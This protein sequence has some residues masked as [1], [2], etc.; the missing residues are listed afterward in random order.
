MQSTSS[1]T[2]TNQTKLL[3]QQLQEKE[4]QIQQ[5]QQELEQQKKLAQIG[6]EAA[7]ILHDVVSPISLAALC[8]SASESYCKELIEAYERAVD[9]VDQEF[10]DEY[11][12]E[13]FLTKLTKTQR[14]QVEIQKHAKRIVGFAD[15]IKL[16]LYPQQTQESE[17]KDV[18]ISEL[19]INTWQ[20]CR[21]KW[22]RSF[23]IKLNTD[24]EF[25]EGFRFNRQD[26]ERIILNLFD[27]A[28]Y[29]V[30]AKNKSLIYEPIVK[31]STKNLG[32]QLHLE[33]EDNGVG[34]PNEIK[35]KLFNPFVTTKPSYEGTGLGLA[36]VKELV[37]K[38]KGN[39][40]VQSETGHYTKFIVFFP[41]K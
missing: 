26:L 5:L 38:H 4:K 8:A 22:K 32:G 12:G 19:I 7:K 24:F 2:T 23:D 18:N 10:L 37:N 11:L 1:N 14:S 40:A 21:E 27:N 6:E 20:A 28:C 16:F 25:L 34:L 29:A 17:L 9:W 41:L 36:I 3:K 13:D 39:I 31:V 33:I 30:W 35:D 15:K